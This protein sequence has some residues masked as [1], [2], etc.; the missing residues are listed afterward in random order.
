M[1]IRPGSACSSSAATA[2]ASCWATRC[3]ARGAHV[4]YVACYRRAPPSSGAGL[5]EVLAQGRAHALTLTSS[6]GLDNLLA[7]LDPGARAL[8][9]R[10]PA[11]V[12]HPRIA[13]HATRAGFTAIATEGADAGLVAG[14]L[15]WFA[16]HPAHG[17]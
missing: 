11:F 1:R 9:Q 13:A 16:S 3:A 2:G 17:T 12:P 7:L 14:L 15:E 6:E 10:L 4:D 5:A 8:L